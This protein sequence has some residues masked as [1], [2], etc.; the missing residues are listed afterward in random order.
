MPGARRLRS[1]SACA[2][3]RTRRAARP[4]PRP[5]PRRGSV[6]ISGTRPSS[7]STLGAASAGPSQPRSGATSRHGDTHSLPPS[8]VAIGRRG[9]FTGSLHL[10][11]P[12]AVVRETA[13]E[14]SCSIPMPLLTRRRNAHVDGASY[15][16]SLG[17]FGTRREPLHEAVAV[18]RRSDGIRPHERM[19][20][21]GLERRVVHPSTAAV[22]TS[23]S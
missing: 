1:P 3:A 2:S 15:P 9:Q 14:T 18:H 16:R 19:R 4:S 6:S 17:A 23:R 11:I 20:E 12:P 21:Q 8:P 5:P 7:T 22:T 10:G 13:S